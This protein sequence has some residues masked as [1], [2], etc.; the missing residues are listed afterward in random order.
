VFDALQIALA[1]GSLVLLVLTIGH[2]ARDRPPGTVLLGGLAVLE[3]GLL[4][5]LVAGVVRLVGTDRDV[6][7][8]VYVGYLVGI[9]LV[10]PAAVLWSAGERSR[11]GT[12]V[13]AV[14]LVVV[15]VLTLRLQ[16]I[17]ASG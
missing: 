11:S 16:Q 1:L 2:I 14:A 4:V 6:S 12:A 7:G 9:L 15:P 3:A 10:V 8:V 5:Q 17:W 13:L